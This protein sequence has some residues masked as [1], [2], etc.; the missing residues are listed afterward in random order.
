MKEL[1][2]TANPIMAKEALDILGFGVGGVKLP[3]VKAN[4][5]QRAG[6]EEVLRQV[7]DIR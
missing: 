1:F 4:A 5:E 2:I 7:G 3:L 6:M